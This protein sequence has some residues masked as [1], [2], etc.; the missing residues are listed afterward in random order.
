VY[1]AGAHVTSACILRQCWPAVCRADWPDYRVFIRVACAVSL[2][3]LHN[4]SDD[5]AR[6]PKPPSAILAVSPALFSTVR[7]GR[8]L[9]GIATL[10]NLEDEDA[11]A[12]AIPRLECHHA[13]QT[14]GSLSTRTFQINTACVPE[15][16]SSPM[17]GRLSASSRLP[18]PYFTQ[19]RFD[20]SPASTTTARRLRTFRPSCYTMSGRPYQTLGKTYLMLNVFAST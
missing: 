8:I 5:T 11:R 14:A 7:C 17:D 15:T 6:P 4:R 16:A 20:S 2:H 13:G 18:L 12:S 1:S 19:S 3:Y 9:T 10:S